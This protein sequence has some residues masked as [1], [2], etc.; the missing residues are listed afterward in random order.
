MFRREPV[1]NPGG[2]PI[3]VSAHLILSDLRRY[4]V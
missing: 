2:S 1:P 3:S 4:M